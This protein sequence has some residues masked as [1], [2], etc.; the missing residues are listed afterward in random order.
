MPVSCFEQCVRRRTSGSIVAGL[1]L[2]ILG[3]TGWI[4]FAYYLLMHILVRFC[5]V[6]R[7]AALAFNATPTRTC[8]G[9]WLAVHESRRAAQS[10]PSQQVSTAHYA[11]CMCTIVYR[12]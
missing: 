3:V 12:H 4:G 11:G 1:T 6:L 10:L 7:K 8:A 2:G 9:G 5:C